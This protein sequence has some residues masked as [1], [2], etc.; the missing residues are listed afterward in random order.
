[1]PD[2]VPRVTVCIPTYNRPEML[3]GCLQSVLWQSMP[4]FEI[5]VS[6]N[7][8]T[9]DTEA[10]VAEF[11]DARVRVSRLDHNIGLHANLTR[12]L[13]LGTGRY[14]VMLPDDDLMLPGNLERKSRFLDDHPEV[15]L[16]HSAFR[17]VNHDSLPFGPVTNWPLLTKDTAQPGHDFITQSIAQGGITCVSSVMLRS[18]LVAEEEFVPD[19]GP[20]CDLALWLRVAQR[21]EVGFLTDPLSGYRVHSG[22][23]SSGF[24]THAVSRRRTVATM[25]HADAVAL[26]H[27]RF[28]QRPDLDPEVA[29]ELSA[30][31][32]DSDRRMRL[33]IRVNRWIPPAGLRLVKRALR[34]GHPGRAYSSLSLY[35]YAPTPLGEAQP[36]RGPGRAR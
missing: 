23:A 14:R 36:P 20:Y 12:C 35:A 8:S 9:T 29:R 26:A 15:G 18:S 2:S 1:M 17:Y 21:C 30:L 16:V 28:V 25:R 10:V 33:S 5:I 13:H 11:G 3:R 27:R 22:S 4:D 32:A 19:D 31:L 24:R 6:D 7:A 34:W